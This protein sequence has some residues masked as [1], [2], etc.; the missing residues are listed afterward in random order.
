[1]KTM[2]LIAGMVYVAIGACVVMAEQEN[3]VSE[4]PIH[5]VASTTYARQ[6]PFSR[7][8]FD[9]SID[10]R[11]VGNAICY[12][13]HRDG[14]SP[15]GESP[16]REQLL[17]DLK[18]M[19]RHW[20]MIRMYGSRGA[21]ETVLPLIR[22]EGL[23]MR[24]VVGA[25]I[26]T[27]A[28]VNEEGQVV[29]AFPEVVKNN[30]SEVES[31]IRLA[32]EYPDIVAAVTVGNETQVSWSSHKV[33]MPVLVNYIRQVR[34]QTRVPVSTADVS[35]YWA[36]PQSTYMSDEVDFIFTHIYAMWNGQP[37]DNAMAWTKQQYALGVARH[38]DQQFVIG[39]AGW[40]TDRLTEGEQARWITGVASE[41]N[42]EVFYRDYLSWTTANQIP[43]FYFEAFD[44]KWKGNDDPSEVEKHWGLFNADRTPKR[45]MRGKN[46]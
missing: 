15:G 40:A 30:R 25:W 44:E 19:S 46:D 7:R 33:R 22:E 17:H 29:E 21:I 5:A 10:S 12:G 45:V 4:N 43:N 9:A 38:P 37:L 23:D 34:D 11:W 26:E 8:A 36:K 6:E 20:N 28:R 3:A 24:V 27:E 14:Q 2:I 31:A 13:P 18:V 42:Q 39:E 41:E 16:T 32:N 1:M 35:T